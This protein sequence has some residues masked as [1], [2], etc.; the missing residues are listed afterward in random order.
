MRIDEIL[1]LNEGISFIPVVHKTTDNDPEGYYGSV[2]PREW[3]D[4]YDTTDPNYNDYN[5]QIEPRMNPKYNPDANVDLSQANAH[6]VMDMLGF[7]NDGDGYFIPIDEFIGRITQWLKQNI[8]KPSQELPDVKSK[9]ATGP[10]IYDMGLPPGYYNKT[11]M[12][13]SKLARLGKEHGATHISA[14]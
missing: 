13:L 4:Y 7:K 2:F 6:S 3:E 12:R 8:N 5:S 10:T 9:T 11:L 14:H 1:N